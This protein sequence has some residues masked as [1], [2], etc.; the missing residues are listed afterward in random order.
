MEKYAEYFA[1]GGLQALL[2]DYR[3]FGEIL[4][5]VIEE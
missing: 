5:T 1:A 2:F 3:G 4:P